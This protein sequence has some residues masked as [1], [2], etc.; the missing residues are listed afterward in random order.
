MKNAVLKLMNYVPLIV[1]VI[2][3]III[4]IIFKNNKIPPHH[5]I[6]LETRFFIV[7]RFYVNA[8]IKIF[9]RLF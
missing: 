3:I 8:E 4:V 2:I 9:D 6:N 1:E 5:H 7:Y